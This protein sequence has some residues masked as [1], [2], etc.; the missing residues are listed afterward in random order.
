VLCYPAEAADLELLTAEVGGA[1]PGFLAA[2]YGRAV[3][4]ALRMLHEHGGVHGE[5][6]P[7]NLIVG[8]L[9]KKINP[10]GKEHRRPAPNSIVRLAEV[11]LIPL[12]PP[13]TQFQPKRNSAPYLP[14]ERL[15]SGMPG[16]WG[17]I[18]GLGA[19]LYFLMTGR[20]PFK[21]ADTADILIQLSSTE[22]TP[23]HALRPDLPREYIEV[24]V[25]MMEKQPDHRPN[26][27]GEVESAL[28]QFCRGGNVQAAHVAV[29]R[30][31]VV[32]PEMNVA[33]HPHGMEGE[34]ALIVPE[35]ATSGGAFDDW[36][37]S[38]ESF[39]VSNSNS[40]PLPRARAMT[41]KDRKRSRL[42]LVLGALLHVTWISLVI[43]WAAGAFSSPPPPEEHPKSPT[44]TPPP[45]KNKKQN[46][47]I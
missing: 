31:P 43:A 4:S 42:L 11:G 33:Q 14:P 3:A 13:A 10:D 37:V 32:I 28:S 20:P 17:D 24:I 23:L 29:P 1:M 12:R 39:S 44:K 21:G 16:P 15:E 19:T 35:H 47:T 34:E 22:P 26:S 30:A 45:K 27:A 2:E 36:G 7:E 5:V 25:K 38:G 8:P 46:P 41:D 18:Y 40:K 6:R 9:S